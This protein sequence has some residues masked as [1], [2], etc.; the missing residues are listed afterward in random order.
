MAERD[1]LFEGDILADKVENVEDLSVISLFSGAGGLDL[2]LEQA[3]FTLSLCVEKDTVRCKTLLANRPLWNVINADIRRYSGKELLK[4]AGLSRGKVTLVAGGPP[5]QPF[6]KSAFW[7]QDRLNR[8][9]ADPRTALLGEYSRVVKE[10]LPFAFIMENVP[11]LAYRPSRPVLD[12]LLK[13]F[14]KYG[15]H[16]SWQTVNAVNYGVPQKRE[17]LFLVGVRGHSIF[18]F[19]G[20]THSP[21][22]N[23]GRSPELSPHVTAGDAISDLDDGKVK[24]VE[25]VRGKWGYLLE[26]IPPGKNYLHLT[27]RRG[28]TAPI[29][30]WRSRYWSYLLKLSPVQPSWTIQAHPGT[31]VGPFHWRNRRLRIP[32]IM[33]LQSFPDTWKLD[34][35]VRQQWA[36]VGD[37]VP[38]LLANRLGKSLIRQLNLKTGA[39]TDSGRIHLR[40]KAL[41]QI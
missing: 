27:K 10:T 41:T 3:G 39:T 23:R 7:V 16:V 2:G 29:F 32:E 34:G 28:T 15:Y 20:P 6:S 31:Y 21:A 33:R 13:R 24:E 9:L 4:E 35:S 5:C 22:E 40:Q 36:Q 38:P 19:P 1:I 11:G 25:R 30:R 12:A 17:R 18:R 26:Q 37:A 14:S 8:I